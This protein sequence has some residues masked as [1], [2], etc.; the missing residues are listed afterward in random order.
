MYI[1]L[2]PRDAGARLCRRD[3]DAPAAVARDRRV[4]GISAAGAL[5]PDLLRPRHDHDLLRGDAVRDRVHE[6]RRAASARCARRRLPD[7]EQRQLL[8]ECFGRTSR[9]PQPVPR[10]VRAYR[11]ARLSTVEREGFF[12]RRRRRLLSRRAADIR[13]RN[14]ADRG[15]F[16]HDH[17]QDPRSGHELYAHAGVLLD[18]ARVEPADACRI[19]GADRRLWRADARPLPRLP[20]L[21]QRRWRQLDAVHEPDL[22]LGASGGLHPR[23]AGVR[24]LFGSGLDLLRQAVVRLP[25]DGLRDARHLHHL[26]HACGCTISSRWVPERTSMPCSASPA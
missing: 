6:L 8:A 17:P 3:H 15:Q 22:G 9:K 26:V 11:L 5:Q 13:R 20:L 21:H 24:N 23:P 10:R 16:R 2:A 19:P 14:G 7:D 18:G 4:A 25:L 12:A 1:V